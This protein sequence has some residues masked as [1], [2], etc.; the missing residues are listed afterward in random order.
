MFLE[1]IPELYDAA[2]KKSYRP[3]LK[4]NLVPPTFPFGRYVS[5]PLTTVCDSLEQLRT[6]LLN[7]KAMSD[8]E[9]FGHKEY[10][11]PPD[12]FEIE[13]KGDCDDF[14]LWTWR[15]LLAMGYRARFVAGRY[16]RFGEGH[17][18]VTFEEEGQHFI[19]DPRFRFWKRPLPRLQVL[20]F[21]PI[22]S[23]E[24]TEEKIIFYSHKEEKKWK[25]PLKRL[26]SLSLEWFWFWA[27]TWIKV[28]FLSPRIA[29]GFIRSKVRRR[30]TA[31]T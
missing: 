12:K 31:T 14:A 23:A 29:A 22:Y 18:W 26:C 1:I 24:W 15:Q 10:W 21:H 28:L 5:Q 30:E 7:C 4:K 13:K 11:L 6:F 9:A 2:G 17:A 20:W 25:L 16:G 27:Y 19:A 8:E 3:H